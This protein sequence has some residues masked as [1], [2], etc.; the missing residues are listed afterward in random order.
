MSYRITPGIFW[1]RSLAGHVHTGGGLSGQN[2]IE[3]RT[4][5]GILH[6]LC[7]PG[8]WM[9]GHP[10][11]L[12]CT[13]P[14]ALPHSYPHGV[15][16]LQHHQPGSAPTVAADA[17]VLLGARAKGPPPD[18]HPLASLKMSVTVRLSSLSRGQLARGIHGEEQFPGTPTNTLSTGELS[19]N[20]VD[21]GGIGV[22]IAQPDKVTWIV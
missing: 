9:G 7:S 17:G 11:L 15:A 18:I 13:L 8:L 14:K 22:E 21:G 6:E 1:R 2:S 3:K 10:Q 19:G 20:G 5:F 12:R 4:K 16:G